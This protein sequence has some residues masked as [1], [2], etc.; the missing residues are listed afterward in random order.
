MIKLSVE[1]Y[2]HN[3]AGFVPI[4]TT[5][6]TKKHFDYIVRCQSFARC[7]AIEEGMKKI[8]ADMREDKE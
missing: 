3:C 6:R 1:S 5:D 4:V 2:C 7:K 8:G